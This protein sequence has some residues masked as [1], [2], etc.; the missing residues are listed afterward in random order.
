MRRSLW[1]VAILAALSMVAAACGSDNNN[2]S[3][4]SGTTVPVACDP[5]TISGA[6]STFVQNIAQQWIKDFQAKCSGAT[7]TYQGV[8]SGAGIQQF[9]AG[10]IDFG[11]S[12]VLM[13]TAEEQGAVAKGGQVT[14]IPWSGGGIA[15]E[16]NVSGV[17]DL[18]LSPA[19]LA[20]IFAGKIKTWNDQAIKNDNSG[21]NLPS[22]GIQVVH[23]SDGSGTTAA[24][25][26]YLTAVAP[27]V[28]TAGSAKD[29]PWP[30]GQGAKG[31]DGVTA[32]VK[33]TSGAI[34]YAEVSFAKGSQLAIASIKNEAGNFEQPDAKN[35]TD[36]LTEAQVPPDLKIK[37]NFKPTTADAYPISTFT[38]VLAYSKQKDPAK[39]KLLK[40]YL[41]YAVGAGQSAATGLFYA[42]LP[43]D[44]Q[45]K[46][47]AAV[48]AI[49]T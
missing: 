49:Q 4:S 45:T 12:D 39:G 33:Q 16:Y 17:T 7:V 22:T 2:K 18:K 35:V 20:G 32:A 25:T 5:G 13:T 47:K 27:T 23:R 38:F 6:G 43:T 42:P 26:G 29:V 48:D 9:T 40:D 24:F 15:I 3:S 28:W 30:T 8:G 19:T 10:T 46:D 34:G 37:P 31:S 36:A 41:T 44:L 1:L 21:A 14:T 11:A